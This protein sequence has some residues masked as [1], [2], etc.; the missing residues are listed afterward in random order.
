MG[1]I[2]SSMPRPHQHSGARVQSTTSSRKVPNE[3][4]S[5]KAVSDEGYAPIG[6]R[7]NSLYL[8][9]ALGKILYCKSECGSDVRVHV[10]RWMCV[11][12]EVCGDGSVWGWRCV[13]GDGGVWRWKYMG[14]EM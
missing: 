7:D 10:W 12:M 5:K 11:E 2:S 3:G 1:T 8:F 13:C 14:M 6:G 9:R 4:P